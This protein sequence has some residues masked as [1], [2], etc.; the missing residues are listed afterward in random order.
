MKSNLDARPV[1]VHKAKLCTSK[2]RFAKAEMTTGEAEGMT[3]LSE[4]NFKKIETIQGHFLI[5]YLSVLLERLL[6][7]NV[8]KNK[9]G[10]EEIFDFIKGFN[11]SLKYIKN[12]LNIKLQFCIGIVHFLV[13]SC[14][15]R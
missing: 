7:F 9:Y 15:T 4:N 8:L 12:W 5:C 3:G 6:Q 1:F 11:L 14:D 13:I 2:T 10:A